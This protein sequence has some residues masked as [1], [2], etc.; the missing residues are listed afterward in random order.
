MYDCQSV[1]GDAHW[2]YSKLKYKYTLRSILRFYASFLESGV[3]PENAVIYELIPEFEKLHILRRDENGEA[4]LD[5][6]ALTFEEAAG[7]DAAANEAEADVRD[8][9]LDELKKVVENRRVKVPGHVD[10]AQ[11]YEH[12]GALGAYT[13]AQL[14]AIAEQG[15]MPY[16][17]EIGKT[18]LIYL[19]YKKEEMD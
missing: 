4:K 19:I 9:L 2:V 1:F 18:P 3:K 10:G 6:P 15:L 12:D 16:R 8:I 17:V 7:F 14:I 5:I 13:T 11:Y